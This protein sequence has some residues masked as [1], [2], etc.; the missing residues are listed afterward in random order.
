MT[1]ALELTAEWPVPTVAAAVIDRGHVVDR[2]GPTDHQFRLASIGK[3]ITAWACL[4]G[5]E[6]GIVSLD[7]PVGPDDGHERTLRHLLSHAGGY[8]FD[9]DDPIK[10]PEQRRIYGNAGINV[11]AE[12]LA[13]AAAMSFEE[14]LRL[15]LLEP[16]GMTSTELRGPPADSMWSTVDDL[17]RFVAEVT[18]PVLLSAD[19]AAMA[20]RPHFPTLGGIVPGV[21]R[22]DTCPWGLG[23]EIRGD[24]D[25]HWTGSRNTSATYGHFGGA[26]TMMWI[27]PGHDDL[28]IVALTDHDFDKWAMH[29][30]PQISDA[31]IEEFA[32][33]S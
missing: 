2:V 10:A 30:W 13:S 29:A 14:Y 24:K 1:R 25:P 33:A 28:G 21:G 6:E 7:D 22:F 5:V 12:H 19:T 15:G 8:G 23:F 3:T 16:L 9:A 26:G 31:V 27:D 4:L 32:G 17:A 20:I 11:A 18:D